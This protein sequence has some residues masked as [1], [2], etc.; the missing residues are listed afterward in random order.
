VARVRER[1]RLLTELPPDL[2]ALV[3]DVTIDRKGR[4]V[5]KL[6][7]KLQASKELRAMLN[8]GGP[9][10]RATDLSRLSDA[11]LVAQVADQAKQLGIE[12]DLNYRFL[13][14]SSAKQEADHKSLNTLDDA[15]DDGA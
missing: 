10:E 13:Q 7:S 15:G 6:Y 11:E 8:I 12:I 1:P 4:A 3:E 9:E 14:A 5:P 2:A